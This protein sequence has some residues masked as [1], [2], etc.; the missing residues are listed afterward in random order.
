[1]DQERTITL[2]KKVGVYALVSLLLLTVD[3]LGAFGW[4]KRVVERMLVPVEM[5]ARTSVGVV[6]RPV[7]WLQFVVSGVDRIADLEARLRE[8]VVEGN[9]L[10]KLRQENEQMRRL[11]GAELPPDWKFTPVRVLG[12]SGGTMVVFGGENVGISTGMS[13]VVEEVFVGLVEQVSETKAV[14][15]LPSSGK[16]RVAGSL[17]EKSTQG[18]IAGTGDGVELTSV[19]VEDELEVGDVVETAGVDEAAAQLLVGRVVE[20]RGQ[21]SDVH[22]IAKVEPLVDYGKLETVFVIV[23][24]DAGDEK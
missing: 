10:V 23:G 24:G 15:R 11:L 14:V 18:I 7:E 19:L 8:R 16:S 12:V 3:S 4:P 20:V 2:W 17:V 9:E 6:S 13:V 21:A 1:M 5:A 22:K